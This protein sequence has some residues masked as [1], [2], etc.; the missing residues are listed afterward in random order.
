MGASLDDETKLSWL[1]LARTPRIG[2]ITFRNL[3]ERFGSAEEA[4][5][6][7]PEIARS[8]GGKP[9]ALPDRSM[10]AQEIETA[11]DAGIRYIALPDIDYPPLM[12]QIPDPPPVLLIRGDTKMTA[13]RAIAVVGSRNASVAG[14]KT[15]S[16]I[17]RDLGSAGCAIVS[18]L[19]RGIDTAAHKASLPTGTVAVLAGGHA[20]IYPKENESLYYDIIENGGAIVSEMPPWA[21][22][23]AKDFPRR[24]R[25]I[26]GLS[27]ATLIVEAA[28]RSGSLITARTALEQDRDVFAI[29]GS[30]LDPRAE[31]CNRLIRDGARLVR[32]A[33]DILEDLN[34]GLS[35]VPPL[36]PE[37]PAQ[38][39][40]APSRTSA[41]TGTDIVRATILSSLSVTPVAID[42]VVRETGFGTGDVLAALADLEI[43]AK[44]TRHGGHRV[45]LA[46][47]PDDTP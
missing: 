20:R 1:Q 29:P 47:Q 25:L 24:N 45:S 34:T 21:E 16:T 10:L 23:R 40:A 30:P 8:G 44:V 41:T 31:G 46:I 22:P 18:G 19:A 43:A 14:Q 27:I 39:N 33:E 5:K 38:F 13:A 28:L 12:R 9:P 35:V 37:E 17:S 3:I 7:L 26:S 6:A 15:A 2:P 4:L 36:F 42:D 32:N 11:Q